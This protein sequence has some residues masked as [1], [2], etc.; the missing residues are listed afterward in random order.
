MESCVWCSFTDI[1]EAGFV[2]PHRSQKISVKH[3]YA[4]VTLPH[5][6]SVRSSS[7]VTEWSPN[8][9]WARLT[10]SAWS[11]LP[12]SAFLSL[13]FVVVNQTLVC[14]VLQACSHAGSCPCCPLWREHLVVG[15][16]I[17]NTELKHHFL[18]RPFPTS[19][20]TLSAL[21]C[22]RP[23]CTLIPRGGRCHT[24]SPSQ[25]GNPHKQSQCFF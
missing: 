8:F 24:S 7:G 22:T 1:R 17:L 16:Y 4:F 9:T 3:K 15:L 20:A 21:P 6:Q 12:L 13:Y 10:N 23:Q 2:F 19:W 5:F 14:S 18:S 11:S 25:A